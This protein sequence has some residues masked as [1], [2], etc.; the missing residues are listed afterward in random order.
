M[1]KLN[2][3]PKYCKDGKYAAVDLHG[4]KFRIGLHGSP[5]SPIAYARFLAESKANPAFHIHTGKADTTVR[6]I[7][8]AF[9]DHAERTLGPPRTYSVHCCTSVCRESRPLKKRR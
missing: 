2:R 3:P 8:A 7:A 5:E 4:K 9:L 1:P 6:E